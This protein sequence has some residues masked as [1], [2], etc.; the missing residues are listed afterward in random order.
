MVRKIIFL[1]LY[2][3]STPHAGPDIATLALIPRPVLGLCC[4]SG[5]NLK[6]LYR[7][8]VFE[9][10]SVLLDYLARLRSRGVDLL[11]RPGPQCFDAVCRP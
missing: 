1:F 11:G 7:S 9:E 2:N 4:G 6:W 5:S 3:A 10:L 8:I